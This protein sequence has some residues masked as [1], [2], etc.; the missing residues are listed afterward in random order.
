MRSTRRRGAGRWSAVGTL[1]AV[2]ASAGLLAACTGESHPRGDSTG[3]TGIAGGG[4]GSPTPIIGAGSPTRPTAHPTVARRPTPGPTPPTDPRPPTL[5][6]VAVP[7][8]CELNAPA[9]GL[10]LS[11][12]AGHVPWRLDPAQVVLQCLRRGLGAA[13][14]RISRIGEHAVA[15]SEPRSRLV[16]RVRLEQPARHGPA[17]IWGV[18]AIDANKELILPLPASSPTPPPSKRP[19]TRATSRG[20]ATPSPKPSSASPAPTAGG[21]RTGPSYQRTTSRSSTTRSAR[22]PT[23][24]ASDGVRAATSGWS[25]PS[26][27]TSDRTEQPHRQNQPPPRPILMRLPGSAWTPFFES[28]PDKRRRTAVARD[29]PF[30]LVT[31]PDGTKPIRTA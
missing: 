12:D 1:A 25:P 31:P 7:A 6:P 20:R 30:P 26:T 3:P 29:Y 16:A 10:Q 11:A 9:D 28:A 17:G 5:R 15:V 22:T 13:A 21:T 18:T 27:A 4:T 24:A 14:W 19:S 2:L 8:A 23:S